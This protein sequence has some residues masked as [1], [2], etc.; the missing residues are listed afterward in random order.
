MGILLCSS[1]ITNL[2][3]ADSIQ[4][5]SKPSAEDNLAH[6][7]LLY[8]DALELARQGKWQ[9]LKQHREQLQSY[10]LYPYLV[11]YSGSIKARHLRNHWL[12]YLAKRQY[13]STF[14][15]FYAPQQASIKQQCQFQ[16]AR[17]YADPEDPQLDKRRAQAL[18][19]ALKLW[20]VGKSQP[21]QCDRL[22]N[23]LIADNRITEALAW[24]RFNKALINHQ[25]QLAR[26]LQRFI[27]TPYYSQ[28]AKLYYQADRSPENIGQF[29][30]F[31]NDSAE[32]C[33][34]FNML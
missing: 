1:V 4:A 2:S 10:P 7:R 32:D 16:L 30:H 20:N 5:I 27:K 3:Y 31:K 19:A 15:R 11:D 6:Q 23:R 22:F 9:R 34:L 12:N 17:Y 13:W 33:L 8:R 24:Q 18:S 25:Y 26:Y 29:Q 14:T 28:L 21:K